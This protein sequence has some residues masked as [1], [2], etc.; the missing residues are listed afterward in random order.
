MERERET[1]DV[2]CVFEWEG[3]WFVCQVDDDFRK[4]RC[5]VEAEAE[6]YLR[7]RF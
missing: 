6:M 7:H 4:T 2:V 3:E 1:S 5:N